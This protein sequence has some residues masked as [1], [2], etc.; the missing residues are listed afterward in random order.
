[1]TKEK[2]RGA[3]LPENWGADIVDRGVILLSGG[4]DSTTACAVAHS[5]GYK[6]L[7]VTFLYGQRHKR[8]IESA[9]AIGEHYGVRKHIF[10]RIELDLIGGSALTDM[11]KVIPENR[12]EDIGKTIPDTYVPARNTIFLSYALAVAETYDADEIFIGANVMDYSGYPDCRPAYISAFQRLANLATKRAMEGKP[13]LIRVPL[14]NLSK[15][16]IIKWGTELGVPY[17]KTWSCY[18]GGEEPC[19]VCDSCILRERGFREVGMQ[20]PLMGGI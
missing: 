17:E 8:E 20:D 4:L 11:N 12:N 13:I 7:A 19:G 15:A 3:G 14:L 9:K 18:E 1:M 5:A 2:D 6:L 16:E 10:P